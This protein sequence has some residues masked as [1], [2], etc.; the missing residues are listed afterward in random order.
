MHYNFF[1][2]NTL[3]AITVQTSFMY[4]ITIPLDYFELIGKD[5]N[6]EIGWLY[7][8][9][10]K[11][12]NGNAVLIRIDNTFRTSNT[13]EG[14]MRYVNHKGTKEQLPPRLY[15][16]KLKNKT[17]ANKDLI[18]KNLMESQ[19]KALVGGGEV[20]LATEV[21]VATQPPK[22]GSQYLN[23]DIGNFYMYGNAYYGLGF[24]RVS[25]VIS[26][27]DVYNFSGKDYDSDTEYY[28]SDFIKKLFFKPLTIDY[29]QIQ[30]ISDQVSKEKPDQLG[31]KDKEAITLSTYGDL[32][33][34]A[35]KLLSPQIFLRIHTKTGSKD[36]YRYYIQS[37][38]LD[39]EKDPIAMIPPAS[40]NLY[41]ITYGTLDPVLTYVMDD[42]TLRANRKKTPEEI[43]KKDFILDILNSR[44]NSTEYNLGDLQET[45]QE[46]LSEL[47]HAPNTMQQKNVEAIISRY[48]TYFPTQAQKAIKDPSLQSLKS[49]A[50]A[51]LIKPTP[52]NPGAS[53][54]L[55]KALSDLT[56]SLNNLTGVLK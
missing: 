20:A 11:K 28:P 2:N 29:P 55:E 37:L 49:L 54:G 7:V 21:I 17:I 16:W 26:D 32:I 36:Y 4:S 50:Q 33:E 10:V 34:E 51:T 14:E 39:I 47:K 52:V 3:I 42:K 8:D 56:T 31:L 6:A 25:N 43:F 44:K 53:N 40:T 38:Q 18:H 5:S 19:R 12:K 48:F 46:F 22:N 35:E 24:Y 41:Y 27:S 30:K 15:E 1:F 13:I 45:Y 9:E 23:A